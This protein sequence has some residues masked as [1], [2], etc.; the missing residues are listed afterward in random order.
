MQPRDVA[1]LGFTD[2]QHVAVAQGVARHF[3]VIHEHSIGA[4]EIF[5]YGIAGPHYDKGM[6]TTHGARIDPQF[7]SRRPANACSP[8]QHIRL[9]LLA[10]DPDQLS[11]SIRGC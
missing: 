6:V 9:G 3:S 5:D 4:V 2:G 11:R 1:E 8:C 10:I 7:A